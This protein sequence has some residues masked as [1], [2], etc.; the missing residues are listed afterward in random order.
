MK[1]SITKYAG[2]FLL[3]LSIAGGVFYN[4]IKKGDLKFTNDP[5]VTTKTVQ[6]VENRPP[7]TVIEAIYVDI[8]GE[9][10]NPGVYRMKPGERIFDLINSAGGVTEFADTSNLNLAM[11]VYDQLV[12]IIPAVESG[13]KAASDSTILVEIKGEVLY[14]G[15]YEMPA[16]SRIKDLIQMAG[17]LSV[18]AD[19]HDISQAALLTDGAAVTIA[20]L[21]TVTMT[22]E[23][24]ILVEIRGEV[25][26]PDCYELPKT[27]LV[28][29]L[30]NLAGGVTKDATL[31]GINLTKPLASGETV[32]I[33]KFETPVINSDGGTGTEEVNDGLIN[34]NTADLDT[35]MT[36]S[37]IGIILGQR[38]IDYRAEYGDFAAI[39]DIMFVS[40]IKESVFAKIKDEIT[41]G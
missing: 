24:K 35:L 37:G 15:V 7:S 16:F 13:P 40:G 10:M 26:N 30:I 9:V 38:I 21:P 41:V 27:A 18:F 14:P 23:E 20:R 11:S 36:L 2:I 6:V 32:I 3:V 25:V 34:I 29:D 4:L 22:D 19:T 17:G 28:R 8:K 12:V 33:K 1:S 5:E 31:E 39:E